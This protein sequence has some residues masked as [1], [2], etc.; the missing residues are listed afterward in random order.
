MENLPPPMA[1]I[2]SMPAPSSTP[3]AEM[4]G[5]FPS[6][7]LTGDCFV[8]D[9]EQRVVSWPEPSASNIP[10]SNAMGMRCWEIRRGRRG[11]R[12]PAVCRGCS[13]LDRTTEERAQPNRCCVTLPVPGMDSGSALVWLREYRPDGHVA[14]R[15][16][17]LVVLG[18]LAATLSADDL[19]QS[20]DK[21][22][23]LLRRAW[24]AGADSCELYLAEPEGR[25][26]LLTAR[27]TETAWDISTQPRFEIEGVGEPRGHAVSPPFLP[28]KSGVGSCVRLPLSRAGRPVGSLTM[29]WRERGADVRHT[30]AALT[31]ASAIIATAVE[32]GLAN[33]RDTV[34]RALEA[35]SDDSPEQ[36]EQLFLEQIV[37]ASGA[38]SGTLILYNPQNGRPT[39]RSTTEGPGVF[40]GAFDGKRPQC[41]FLARGHGM[42]HG[43]RREE[44]PL[45]CRRLPWSIKTPCCLPL[46]SGDELEGAVILDYGDTPPE[47]VTRDVVR[48]L[49]MVRAGHLLRRAP[50][51][52]PWVDGAP[53]PVLHLKCFGAFEARIG[54]RVV[55]SDGFPRKKALALLKILILKAGRP[56]SRPS[57][58]EML[59]PDI[60]ERAGTNRFHVVVH[61]LRSVIEPFREQRRWVYIC[62]DGDL[63]YF[64]VESPHKV[65]L[66]EFRETISK[67]RGADQRGDSR[68]AI[69]Q[70]EKA[71]ALYQ[72]DLFEGD[73]TAE[74]CE[75]ERDGL[76]ATYLDSVRR[77]A[78]LSVL[79]GESERVL[80]HIPRALSIDPFCEDLHRHLIEALI[81]AGRHHEA[82][83]RYNACERILR[84]ELGTV[85]EPA[86]RRLEQFLPGT[87]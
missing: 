74:W 34:E 68:G 35:R 65:D 12:P 30:V 6:Y 7:P 73:H 23:Q 63:Y 24:G 58:T 26:L 28:P 14:D 52:A 48:L 67:A 4:E 56:V 11:S 83:E 29:A 8:V 57:L 1:G 15:G 31:Q 86:T 40:C 2:Q 76:R 39:I 20:L 62:N 61:S 19:G 50:L 49:A 3:V 85:P 81:D 82:R 16:S 71:A 75:W 45:P 37:G 42:P 87:V 9:E 80:E 27:S 77:L 36:R 10:A 18:A 46:L 41:P 54:D 72:G 33:A 44:W 43:S 47:P 59:W 84:E 25:D 17:Q 13:L 55:R 53:A 66:F 60:D 5:L 22:V 78:R 21:S 64:D 79:A 51:P 69:E 38:R 70:F 32:A